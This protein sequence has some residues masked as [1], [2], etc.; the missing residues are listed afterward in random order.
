MFI[1]CHTFEEGHN[2]DLFL[3]DNDYN[4]HMI[5]KKNMISCMDSTIKYEITLGDASQVKS[6]GK[7]VVSILTKQNK[8]ETHDF[9][10]VPN[11]K[12]NLISVGKLT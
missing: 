12:H 7:S 1:S 5:G 11:L 4:N 6:L 9:Y 2:K 10:Y 8:K 3:L